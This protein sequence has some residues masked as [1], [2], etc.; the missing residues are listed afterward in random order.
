MFGQYFLLISRPDSIKS[1]T[2]LI[3]GGQSCEQ[4]HSRISKCL[5]SIASIIRSIVWWNI[6]IPVATLFTATSFPLHIVS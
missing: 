4:M 1:S 2:N 6:L 5:E 3:S